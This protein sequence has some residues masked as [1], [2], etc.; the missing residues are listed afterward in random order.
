MGGT[1][2]IPGFFS[3][4]HSNNDKEEQQLKKRREEVSNGLKQLWLMFS[5]LSP[6]MRAK[7][8][9]QDPLYFWGEILPKLHSSICEQII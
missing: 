2:G 9:R 1:L 8:C 4:V 7:E 3:R 6:E 5:R